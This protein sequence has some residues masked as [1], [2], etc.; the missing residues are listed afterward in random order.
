LL[1]SLLAI[2]LG[3]ADRLEALRVLVTAKPCRESWK[4]V[5]AVSALCLD[6][7]TLLAAGIDHRL[8]I[9]PFIDSL[10]QVFWRRPMIGLSRITPW[11]WLLPPA[12]GLTPATVVVIAALR[13]GMAACRL[14]MSLASAFAHAFLPEGRRQVLLIKLNPSPLRVT[15][16]LTHVRIVTALEYG[17]NPG[18]TP[19]VYG[20][21]T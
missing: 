21:Q 15:K 5:A 20:S 6:Y 8:R 13:S 3:D 12:R 16:C 9:A 1:R 17:L 10:A 2:V 4:T 19:Q 11:R 14:T 7:F 18:V